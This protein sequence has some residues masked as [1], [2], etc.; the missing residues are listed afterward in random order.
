[1]S[2]GTFL[3]PS[4]ISKLGKTSEDIE[5]IEQE[6]RTFAKIGLENTFTA[7]NNFD[8]ETHFRNKVL[9]EGR[10]SHAN[11]KVELSNFDY[12]G[13]NFTAIKFQ[14][15]STNKLQIQTNNTN[16]KSFISTGGSND[17]S[18]SNLEAPTQPHN[19]TNKQYV[20]NR[21]QYK[22]VVGGFQFTRQVIEEGKVTKYWAKR[23]YQ[24]M[25]IPTTAKIVSCYSKGIP[26]S[27]QHLVIT[28]FPLPEANHCLI[29]IY[30]YA[31]ATDIKTNLDSNTYCFSYQV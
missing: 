1:M 8:N 14:I 21:T 25:Q 6:L 30:Q 15:D 13:N 28:F 9:F 31:S 27:G 29:E 16:G 20:D 22:E 24:N 10:G 12:E 19:A 18:I 4:L 2:K 23:S 5:Q 3:Y 7:K 26:A 17:L 11:K